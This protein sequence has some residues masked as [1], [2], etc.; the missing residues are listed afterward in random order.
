MMRGATSPGGKESKKYKSDKD[1]ISDRREW[2]G[3][4]P[5]PPKGV[6]NVGR[7][8]QALNEKERNECDSGMP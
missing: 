8:E 6:K 5:T 7:K 2:K 4:L 3:R 1:N